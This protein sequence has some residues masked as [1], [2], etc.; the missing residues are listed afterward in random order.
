M[1][2]QIKGNFVVETYPQSGETRRRARLVESQPGGQLQREAPVTV[3]GVR[4]AV[5]FHFPP[6]IRQGRAVAW[7][8]GRAPWE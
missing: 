1:A 8:E 7:P 2:I 3:D 5:A 6:G 4:Y